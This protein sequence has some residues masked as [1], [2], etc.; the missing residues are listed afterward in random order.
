MRAE[1]L[2]LLLDTSLKPPKAKFQKIQAYQRTGN[3]AQP[4]WVPRE[5]Q[6]T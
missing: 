4:F 2:K 5:F 6:V 3:A 1:S